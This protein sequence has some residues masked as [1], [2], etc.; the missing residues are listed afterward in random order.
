M[1][2]YTGDI[3]VGR[4]LPVIIV[5][6]HVVTEGARLGIERGDKESGVDEKEDTGYNKE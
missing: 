2:F 1:T 5:G 6:L 4:G 3:F